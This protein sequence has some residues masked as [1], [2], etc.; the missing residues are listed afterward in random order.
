MLRTLNAQQHQQQFCAAIARSSQAVLSSSGAASSSSSASARAFATT[1][2]IQAGMKRTTLVPFMS[3][4]SHRCG[5]RI[6]S[7]G[8]KSSR[9]AKTQ[10]GLLAA[11][12][13]L[14]FRNDVMSSSHNQITNSLFNRA[15]STQLP[16]AAT[17]PN[18]AATEKERLVILGSGWAGYRLLQD[19]D[20]E[21]YQVSVVSPRNHFLFTPLLAS[22]SVGGSDISS[23]CHP[24]RPLVAEKDGRFYEARA[25]SLDKK[26]KM[27]QCQTL[28]GREF[29][30]AYDKLVISIGFQAND[31]GIK[32][33]DQHAFFMKE[34]ADAKRVHDHILRSF[35]EASFIHM[36]DGDEN[37]SLEEEEQIR[38]VLSFVVVGGGPTGTEFCGEL[39][40]F[41]KRDIAVQYPH[42]SPYWSVHLI[43]AL[44][45]ILTPF[46]NAE[47]QAHALEH[48]REKQGVQVHL[49]QFVDK[50]EHHRIYLKSGMSFPFSTLVWC[51]GIKPLPFVAGL[52][53]AKNAK[54][55]Q[56][57]TDAQL[58]VKG[59]EK[60]GI[61]ALGDCASIETMPMPQTAQIAS[62]E[63][64]YLAKALS[65][66]SH[67]VPN[68]FEFKDK[69]TLAYLGGT[70]AL[71]RVPSNLPVP[72]LRGLLGWFTW[73]S[74]YWSMQLSIRNKFMLAWNWISN[75]V[76][77]RDLTRV[78]RH[79]S[80]V[81]FL[82]DRKVSSGKKKRNP[83]RSVSPEASK[84]DPIPASK[85]A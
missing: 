49:S 9:S 84:A 36:L 30:L 54:G 61:Y 22:A 76:F 37:V 34:T 12:G 66:D 73:R 25:I 40:D 58:R 62:Q 16:S 53:L 85:T 31:F 45:Q 72:H 71:Y 56:L 2:V 19:V 28:D 63:A 8:T 15:F 74:A 52:D 64:A 1:R 46:Q 55:T 57:L 83:A 48:L 41:L 18:P 13:Q 14:L 70:S 80:P 47:L 81:E 65:L 44:P 23:I 38:E 78:G 29:P 43:D 33:L 6:I 5:H 77:G 17:T 3:G 26:K 75:Y 79:S 4:R 82:L 11:P 51:A 20:H 32:D 35:E 39:T 10:R 42:L 67:E 59:E 27:I 7:A 24:V 60:N 50:I 69:G 21:K 68:N